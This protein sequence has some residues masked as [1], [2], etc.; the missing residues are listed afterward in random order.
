MSPIIGAD[1]KDKGISITCVNITGTILMVSLPVIAGIIY[2]S[3]TLPSSALIGGTVQ[4]IGQVI[5]SA[6]LMND[7]VVEL[8]T[9]FKL[10]RVMLIV[11]IAL[12]FERLNT[13]DGEPLFKKTKKDLLTAKEDTENGQKKKI[14]LNIPWFIYG[15][16]LLFILRSTFTLP[17]TFIVASK[18]IST[19]FE[20]I[21]LAAIGVRVKFA[22]IIKEGPK[23]LTC[24]VLTGV[25]QVLLAI[26]LIEI[27]GFSA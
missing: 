2:H 4:S 27:M 3:A 26:A 11:A 18:T 14:K 15:F 17:D 8:S 9:V 1:S 25:I 24:S 22:D 20:I 16:I 7:S 21:A 13:T 12:A 23:A 6:K 19:Q 5:A 10:I